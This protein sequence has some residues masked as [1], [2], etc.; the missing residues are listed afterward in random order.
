M[1]GYVATIGMFDG[2]HRG[3]QFVLRQV[4]Q[5]SVR[6]RL[7][8]MVVTFDGGGASKALLTPL[9]R[10]LALIAQT[11]VERTEVLTF[12]DELR[13]MTARQFM[14]QVLLRQFNVKVL[15]TGYDNRFGY[16]RAEGFDDYVRYGR[17]LGMEVMSLPPADGEGGGQQVSSSCIRQ[18]LLRGDVSEASRC[19]GYD[20]A[21][22]GC[23]AHGHHIG[24]GMGFPTANIVPDSDLQLIPASGV[25]AV[26]VSS[27]ECGAWGEKRGMMNI[28]RRPTFDGH[29]TTL[30]VHILGLDADLYGQHL[31][32]SFVQRLR[33]ERHFETV[34]ALREQLKRDALQAEQLVK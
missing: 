24:T 18:L 17:E 23:V 27:V 6:R 2:V 25:Y 16:N 7:G 4:V 20:Y 9:D 14:E 31:Q 15:L 32:V 10:K 8:S 34:E 11:G 1:E 28:G 5:T 29:D 21:L 22:R 26:R 3:H 19:L 13:R 30:E 12:S 33:D